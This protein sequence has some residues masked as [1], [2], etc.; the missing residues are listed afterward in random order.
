[1][2]SAHTKLESK[3]VK[4][5]LALQPLVRK[6][7]KCG[8]KKQWKLS[9]EPTAQKPR[10]Y[11]FLLRHHFV[12]PLEQGRSLYRTCI[13]VSLL[14]LFSRPTLQPNILVSYYWNLDFKDLPLFSSIR[15]IYLIFRRKKI[16]WKNSSH[17]EKSRTLERSRHQKSCE[18]RVRLFM[19]GW[20]ATWETSS[21]R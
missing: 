17:R 18:Y 20:P 11:F 10:R 4:I 12:L 14:G 6:L 3:E 13:L 21:E 1:M 2:V 16:L 15:I 5:A 19:M 9:N 7:A 8:D